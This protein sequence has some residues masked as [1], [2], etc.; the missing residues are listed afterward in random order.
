[1]TRDLDASLVFQPRTHLGMARGIDKIVGAIR[2]TLGPTPRVVAIDRLLDQRM[3]EILDNGAI[4][5]KRIIELPDRDEDAGAMLIRDVVERVGEQAGDGTATAAVIF[6]HIFNEGVR[7]LAGGG[8]VNVL[9]RHLELGAACVEDQLITRAEPISGATDL[10][11]LAESLCRDPDMAA[12]IGD[13]FDTVGEYGR[14]EV[15]AGRDRAM[16]REF[17]EGTYWNRGAVSRSMLTDLG[18]SRTDFINGAILLSD[19]DVQDPRQLLPVVVRA[20][21]DGVESLLI[22]VGEISDGALAF[23]AAN[24]DSDRFT[25]AVVK[26]PG[27]GKHESAAALEDLAILTGGRPFV[28]AAGDTFDTLTVEDLG[29]ARRVWI[30][31]HTFGIVGGRGDSQRLRRHING[32]EALAEASDDQVRRDHLVNRVGSLLGGSATLWMGGSTEIQIEERVDTAK[33]TVSAMRGAALHGVVPGG[34]TALLDCRPA[35]D[36]MMHETSHPDAKAAYRMLGKAIAQPF[37]AIVD[38]A[39]Y[40]VSETIA[41]VNQCDDGS[42]FDVRTGNIANMASAGIVDAVAVQRAAIH[43]AVTS[44]AL[45]L[46]V[47]VLVRRPR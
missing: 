15:R 20:L 12:L 23:L 31:E 16:R 45:A 5:A 42:G 19:I 2:P 6:Q 11:R 35:L 27:W 28:D 37:C 14:I 24:N 33:R 3:P 34:G 43:A 13:V 30:G 17:V 40:D 39:G 29:R 8:D 22:V 38:N 36:A 7:H 4:I 32:L 9:R 21:K 25:S 47:D 46:S 1:M 41:Q 18:R 44:A 26:V 10:S